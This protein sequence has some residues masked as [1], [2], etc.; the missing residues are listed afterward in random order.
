M[1]VIGLL[2]FGEMLIVHKIGSGISFN[3]FS[4]G[5]AEILAM[6]SSLKFL[7]DENSERIAKK[8]KMNLI[9]TAIV[10]FT[11]TIPNFANDC[12]NA[13]SICAAKVKDLF[14]LTF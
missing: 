12:H 5:L 14:C 7:N 2:Y 1:L 6:I 10:G 4:Y 8:I 9:V 13:T 3:M 11:I